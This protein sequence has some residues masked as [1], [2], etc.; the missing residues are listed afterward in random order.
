M[1]LPLSNTKDTDLSLLTTK[2]KAILDPVIKNPLNGV[3]ILKNIVL[4]NGETKIPHLLSQMQ[5]G[6]FVTDSNAAATIYRSKPLNSD[7][8]YLTS[9]VAVTISLGVF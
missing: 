7:F 4:I 5:Q 9:N 2:W 1:Q 8:L 6:W 3:L